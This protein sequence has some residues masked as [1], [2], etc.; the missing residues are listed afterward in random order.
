LDYFQF[1]KDLIFYKLNERSC[2]TKIGVVKFISYGASLVVFSGGLL[3]NTW[4]IVIYLLIFH[5]FKVPGLSI[6]D[7]GLLARIAHWISEIVFT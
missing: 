2:K 4:S 7:I 3:I 1:F 5:I 6:I